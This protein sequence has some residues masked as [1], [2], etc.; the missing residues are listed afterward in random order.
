MKFNY[1]SV[2]LWTLLAGCLA[3]LI[4]FILHFIQSAGQPQIEYSDGIMMY[5]IKLTMSHGWAW[6]LSGPPHMVQFYPP[7]GYWSYGIVCQIFGYSYLVARIFQLCLFTGCLAFIFLIV[8]YFTKNNLIALIAALLPFTQPV[9]AFWTIYIRFDI[10]AILFELAALYVVLKCQKS[11]W[12]F[13]AVPLF[14]LAVYTKQSMVSGAI[15]AIVYLFLQNKKK[16]MGF[17]GTYA[18]VVAGIMGIGCL[19]THGAFF[20]EMITYQRTSPF[21]YP[22]VDAFSIGFSFAIFFIPVIFLAAVYVWHNR[23][24]LFS[25]YAIAAIVVNLSASLKPGSNIYYL[26]PSLMA[27]SICAGLELSRIFKKPSTVLESLE[28]SDKK[29]RSVYPAVIYTFLG[30]YLVA[31][32][33]AFNSFPS[34]TPGKQY[35]ADYKYAESLISDAT[36]PILTESVGIVIDAGKTPYLDEP[37]VFK[38]FAALGIWSDAKM[39]S[40]LTTGKIEYVI[41]AHDLPYYVNPIDVRF[42][43]AVQ[44]DIVANYHIVYDCS[45]IPFGFVIYK[46]N[47]K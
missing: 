27:L 20:K 3:L 37:F 5:G 18:V 1:R 17:A 15:A 36:Y 47:K 13:L 24:N 6:N 28:L 2:F 43:A 22:V 14:V 45:D 16:A 8:K 35:D 41:A 12:V 7:I 30:F 32:I 11:R 10:L 21:L 44:N 40:D 29:E 26:Y 33:V 31:S 25:F 34:Q 23:R 38:N 4:I 19:L 46:A 42:S 39:L 9:M